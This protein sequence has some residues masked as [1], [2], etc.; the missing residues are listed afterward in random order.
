[1]VLSKL[2]NKAQNL[3]SNVKTTVK[4]V[5]KPKPAPVKVTPKVSSPAPTTKLSTAA[6]STSSKV[7]KSATTPN[8][9]P[10]PAPKK[11]NYNNNTN[12]GIQGKALYAELGDNGKLTGPVLTREMGDKTFK[13]TGLKMQDIKVAPTADKHLVNLVTKSG[14][15]LTTQSEPKV[16]PWQPPPE[17]PIKYQEDKVIQQVV[18]PTVDERRQRETTL[19]DLGYIAQPTGRVTMGFGYG[20]MQGYQPVRTGQ[21][22]NTIKD[23]AADFFQRKKAVPMLDPGYQQAQKSVDRLFGENIASGRN[24]RAQF[25]DPLGMKKPTKQK[26]K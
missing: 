17:M 20:A 14:G 7:F 19:S 9:S 26:R 18:Q 24:F 11:T 15:R 21:R 13:D 23:Y 16:E 3:V 25:G 1:M 22:D 10:A 4:N 8:Y 5:V 6:P 2:R 12:S